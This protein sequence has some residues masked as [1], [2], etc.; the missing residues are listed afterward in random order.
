MASLEA[1]EAER[2]AYRA[3]IRDM[4]VEER[5]RE[6]LSRYGAEALSTAE[7]LAILLRTGTA[8]E[9]AVAVAERL[10][11]GNGSLKAL[12]NAALEEMMRT[13]GVGRV[14]AIEI[15]AAMELGK[16]LCAFTE[17]AMPT[18]RSAQD[19]V[20]LLMAD[21]RHLPREEF[22]ILLLTTRCQVM[23]VKTISVGTL[24]GSLVHPREVFREAI[25]RASHSLICAHNHPSGDP[26]PS[27]DD[28]AITR[29]LVEAGRLIDIEVL[30]HVII[31]SRGSLSLKEKGLM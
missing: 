2:G 11:S 24:N 21:M 26:S 18:I 6:R 15:K 19:V 4:P 30:D 23:A 31:G 12:A 20:N 22:R 25:A 16:R 28:I 27:P 29:R 10:L 3:M 8:R 5:P 7:L 13:P 14:K 9:G 1:G 17:D